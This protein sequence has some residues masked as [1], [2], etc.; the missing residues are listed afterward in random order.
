MGRRKRRSSDRRINRSQNRTMAVNFLLQKVADDFGVEAFSV[1]IEGD[2]KN[3]K[4]IAI[5]AFH[6]EGEEMF[7]TAVGKQGTMRELGV[8]RAIMGIR[9]IWQET[10]MA[11]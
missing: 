7:L 10:E 6:V 2:E 9:R 1:G 11:A 3:A 4:E 5:R 8:Y